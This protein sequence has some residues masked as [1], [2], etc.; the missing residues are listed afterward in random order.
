MPKEGAGLT[1]ID[2]LDDEAPRQYSPDE[3]CEHCKRPLSRY[4]PYTV[5]GP[6]RVRVVG[7]LALG[8]TRPGRGRGWESFKRRA[9]VRRGPM[10]AET[11]LD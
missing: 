7:R 3:K 11:P 2:A 1:T 5:C 9:P 4:N 8:E 10:L 6:C